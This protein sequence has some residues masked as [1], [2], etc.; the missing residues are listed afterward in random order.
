YTPRDTPIS[1]DAR[2]DGRAVVV[3]VSDRGPGFSVENPHMLFEKF[4]RGGQR[5]RT[6]VGLGL[7]IVRGIV[8]AHGGEVHAENRQDGG[9]ILRFTI[10]LVG[11]PPTVQ[12]EERT[13]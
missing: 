5:D 11:E 1:I 12:L 4:V 10:P 8:Q 9:A 3:E 7:A 2:L 6:G 13:V